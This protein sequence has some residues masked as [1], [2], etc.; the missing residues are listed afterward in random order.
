MK[1]LTILLF[2]IFI[3]FNSYSE[4]M[5]IGENVNGTVLYIDRD[6][7]KEHNDYVYFWRLLDYLKPTKL[8]DISSKVYIQADCGVNRY[9]HLSFIFYKQQMG[10]GEGE[11]QNPVNTEWQYPPPGS[12]SE[13]LLDYACSYIK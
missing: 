12:G 7:I 1:K 11:Q 2:S 8:G 3:S 5:K 9:K 13:S 4:W 6:K 10:E